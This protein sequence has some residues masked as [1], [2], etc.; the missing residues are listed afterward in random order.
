MT[1][2]TAQLLWFWLALDVDG[3]QDEDRL[4]DRGGAARAAA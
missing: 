3:V 1:T 2:G 4:H